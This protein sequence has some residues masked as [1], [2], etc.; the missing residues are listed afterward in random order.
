MQNTVPN[1]TFNNAQANARGALYAQL[2]NHAQNDVLQR[3]VEKIIYDTAPKQF[4]DLKMLFDKTPEYWNTDEFEYYELP[5]D[6]FPLQVNGSAAAVSYPQVQVVP[7][8][9][10]DDA[11][12]DMAVIYPG[13]NNMGTITAINPGVSVTVTPQTNDT[14]PAVVSGDLLAYATP[15]EADAATQVRSSY[16]MKTQRQDN[17]IQLLSSSIT[18]GMLELQKFQSQNYLDNWLQTEYDRMINHFR[19]SIS[20]TMWYSKRGEY[21]LS[22]GTPAKS[23]EGIYQSLVNR[24]GPVISTPLSSLQYAVR[25]AAL[26]TEF[27]N[28][29]DTKYLFGTNRR[30]LSLSEQLKTQPTRYVPNDEI[31]KLDL[32]KIDIGS[33]EIVFVPMKRFEDDA[34][35][36]REFRDFMFLINP[37]LIVP[38]KIR[39]WSA[40]G[41]YINRRNGGGTNNS[42]TRWIQ[43]SI[44][45]KINLAQGN[46]LIKIV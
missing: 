1:S 40:T 8:A 28:Y 25:D 27:G 36:P 10:T 5:Y 12:L 16:R 18:Y 3:A 43:D 2:F 37:E 32:K 44:G 46:A 30:L 15:V 35:F 7:V 41:E 9:S 39:N 26:N 17:F 20:N 19:V 29:G 11:F 21:T 31:A 38:M 4:F 6:R 14:L 34:S 23:T 13:G 22:D 33:T 45:F 24:Q 42:L